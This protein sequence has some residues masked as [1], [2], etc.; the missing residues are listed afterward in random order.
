[1]E[2]NLFTTEHD[3]FRATVR[4]FV[5]REV[6]PN[7]SAWEAD[8]IV[9]RELF[10]KTAAL[11][12][13]GLQIPEEFG[14]GGVDS[15]CYPA[16]VIEEI[17]YAAASV[18]GLQV[19]LSTVLPY[20]LEYA[21]YEQRCRWFPGFA[22]GSLVSSIAMT[23]PGAGSDLAGMATIAVRDGGDWVLNG[24]KTFITGGIN[25]DL[26]IVVARTSREVSDRRDGLSL[27]VVE[28]GTR[29]FTK[30]RKLDKLG[31]RAQDTAELAFDDVRV[32]AANLLGREGDGFSMLLHNLPQERL[33]IAVTAQATAT[34]AL[35]FATEYVQERF[36]FEQRVA[37]F[38]N[39]KF[40]L[41]DCATQLEAGQAVVD[42]AIQSLD[43][44]TLTA[45]DAAKVKLFCTEMQ[46]Q[47]IDRCL[48][49]HGGYGYM[50]EYPISRLYLDARVT[51]IFGGTNEVMKSVIS[52]SMGL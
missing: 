14:G 9:P 8:G 21:D 1:M 3:E 41:A 25:A 12:I 44:G 23:E 46:A 30:G 2:R 52:K 13:N 16:V 22:D 10:T 18:G 27:F 32:A 38:Q 48:Q 26:V 51:R 43:S 19:H 40:V 49:L 17:G 33:T 50:C 34:A 35:R 28:S 45:A 37:D 42:H 4:R 24:A 31:L 36:V 47:V 15:F 39:T 5:A 29:G 11:G 7:V 6:T 20:F